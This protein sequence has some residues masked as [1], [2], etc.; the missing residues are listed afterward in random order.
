MTG[1]EPAESDPI[2]TLVNSDAPDLSQSFRTPQALAPVQTTAE[3]IGESLID[4]ADILNELDW[5]QKKNIALLA[6]HIFVSG[7]SI[8][9]EGIRKLWPIGMNKRGDIGSAITDPQER[10]R[11]FRAGYRPELSQ[12]QRFIKTET[13]AY[14][15]RE[16]GIEIDTQDMGLTAEQMGFLTVLANFADGKDLKKKLRDSG[17][18]WSKYQAWLA[19]PDFAQAYDSMLKNTIKQ[20]VPFA[21]QQLAAKM[22]AGDSAAAKLGFEISGFHDPANKKQV[23]AVMLMQVILE[24]LEEKIKDKDLLLDIAASFQLRGAKA[25]GSGPES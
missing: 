14:T 23:D 9:G 21:A 5:R 19:Q 10:G 17:V 18:P 4:D 11:I 16:F 7:Q 25:L 13:F 8:T 1:P 6:R 2:Y 22:A 3:I 12:I 15:M 24:V 20:A